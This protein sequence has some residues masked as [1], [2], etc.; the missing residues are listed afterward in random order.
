ME[1]GISKMCGGYDKIPRLKCGRQKRVKANERVR[2]RG[3]YKEK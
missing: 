2:D 1:V 3:K